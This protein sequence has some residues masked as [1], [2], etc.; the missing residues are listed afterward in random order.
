MTRR[1][2]SA[3]WSWF[4]GESLQ[5]RGELPDISRVRVRIP[6]SV[7]RD[8]RRATTPTKHNSEPLA[9]VRVRYASEAQN[10]VIVAIGVTPFEDGAY[11]D[12][13]AGAN[14]DTAYAIEIANAEICV[15][16]GVLLVHQHGGR[17][18]PWFSRIDSQTNREVMLQLT[19]GVPYAPYG[20]IVLSDDSAAAVVARDRRLA[21]ADVIVVPD[22]LGGID[23]PA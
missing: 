9:F 19:V 18:E 14:F 12:G 10:G 11:V 8:L 5:D 6:E 2:L 15:N 17:G 13:D 20:A 3:L 22:A 23:L 16:A 7:M 4:R 21:Q 1:F